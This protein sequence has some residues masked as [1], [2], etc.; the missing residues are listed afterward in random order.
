MS[1]L[2]CPY[3]KIMANLKFAI[4]GTGFWA[5]FQLAG[6]HE[7]GGVECV[8]LYNRTRRKAEALGPRFGVPRVYDDAEALLANEQLDFVD[9]ITDVDTHAKF[10][11]LA[12]AHK[13]PVICQKPMAPTLAIAEVMVR[14][15]QQAGVPLFIHENWRWQTPIRAL[16]A[17]LDQG[18]IGTP[19]RARIDMISGFP[20]FKNQP[21]LAD[22]E[23]FIITDL[24]SHTLDV[25]RFFF[26]EARSLY[27]QTRRVHPN[28]KGEDVATM[29]MSMS[30]ITSPVSGNE[31]R[32][33]GGTANAIVT[34]NMAYAENYLEHDR[35]PETYFFVEGDKGSIELG[36]DFWLRTTT[37]NGTHARRVPPPR[38]AWADPAYDVVHASIVGCNADLLKA[39]K[40]EGQAE[41]T[42]EDNLKTVR[43]VFGSYESAAKNQVLTF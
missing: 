41:T 37:A 40:G 18:L 2:L 4:F 27:C 6:W 35:F 42:G 31:T 19:F 5:Q 14:A 7:V 24:G 32:I 16:K 25:A 26:G 23:Q 20:V 30:P 34:V 15:C 9:I 13:V 12:A 10:T 43:L 36:P 39:L 38:Y 1:P 21:F 3:D 8:A 28:I 33:T 22:L 29:V 17:A 11:Q